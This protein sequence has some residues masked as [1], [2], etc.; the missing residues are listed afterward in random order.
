MNTE[1]MREAL[2]SY[3]HAMANGHRE[4]DA[5]SAFDGIS[6]PDLVRRVLA[7]T[8]PPEPARVKCDGN[9]G[10]PRCADP[11]CWNDSLGQPAKGEVPE[12]CDV[13]KILLDIVPGD[14]NGL[15][16]FAKNVGEVVDKLTELAVRLDE[17]E[18]KL[19]ARPAHVVNKT[20]TLPGNSYGGVAL[21]LGNKQVVFFITEPEARDTSDLKVTLER[22]TK[23]GVFEMTRDT[24]G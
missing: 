10:G 9:H 13:R 22:Y 7:L 21:W 1:Q 24:Q 4:H 16:V 14:G 12:D 19:A 15:E 20:F 6:V 23:R 8:H 5:L 2:E 3:E 18:I 17:A 11:E